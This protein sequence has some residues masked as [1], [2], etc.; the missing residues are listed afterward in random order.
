MSFALQLDSDLRVADVAQAEALLRIAQEGITNALRHARSQ[1]LR[2]SCRRDGAQI[3]LCVES[4][5]P[6]AMPIQFGN[7]LTGIQER[8]LALD[9]ELQLQALTPSGLRLCARLPD[10]PA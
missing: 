7:G 2:L 10:A 9:G 8:L 6:V 5:G 3:E 1:T 4:D